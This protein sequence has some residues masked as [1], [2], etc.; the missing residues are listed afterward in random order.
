[1]SGNWKSG[2]GISGIGIAILAVIGLVFGGAN[3]TPDAIADTGNRNVSINIIGAGS[4]CDVMEVA[5][6]AMLNR[7]FSADQFVIGQDQ[8][9]WDE[10]EANERGDGAF[11]EETPKSAAQ[12]VD[13]LKADDES[14]KAAKASLLETSGAT[15]EELLTAANWVPAQF[16]TSVE[17]PGNTAFSGG[18]AQ[19]VGTRQSDAGE[20]IWLFVNP[21]ACPEIQ[22]AAETGDEQKVNQL[23]EDATTA[24]RAGCGNPQT[25][26]PVPPQD[27]PPPATTPPTTGPPGTAP[28]TTGKP[29]TTTTTAPCPPGTH[30]EGSD[31]IHDSITDPDPCASN[32]DIDVCQPPQDNDQDTGPTP[33]AP[34]EPHTPPPGPAPQEGT[35]AP[36]PNDGGYDSGSPDGSGTPGGSTCDT[37]G[38]TG[39]GATPPSND[40]ED[41]GQG[42]D[43]TG[44][45]PPPP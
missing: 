34:P 25:E 8:I 4:G 14:A 44:T 13:Q 35:P 5:T 19:S 43:N 1:M 33:G 24:H 40:P 28:P 38:C 37:S 9:N 36:P 30:R 3:S 32:P 17:L 45:V 2:V 42:G 22:L 20:V 29:P 27:A 15:E 31:C 39:G 10:P 16:K 12:V 6:R 41:S 11:V 7:G 18:E 26:L 23:A 21:E